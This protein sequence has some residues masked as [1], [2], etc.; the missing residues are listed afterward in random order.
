MKQRIFALIQIIIAGIIMSIIFFKLQN[1]GQ[2]Y[3]LIDAVKTAAGNWPYLL[4]TLIGLFMSAFF[5]TARWGYLL[6]AQ[7]INLKFSRQFTLYMIGQ[8]F[9]AFMLGSTGGDIVK[10]YYAAT[11]TKHLRAEVVATVIVDRIVGII[12]L[13]IL[14]TAITILR[15]NFFLSTPETK[16]AMIFNIGFMLTVTTGLLIIFKH[17]LF[18]KWRIFRKFEESTAPGRII[19]RVYNAMQLCLSKS[20][21]MPKVLFLSFLNHITL[22]TWSYY[23]ALAIGIPSGFIDILTV[24][25][26]MN[27]VASI[28]LTPNGLGTRDSTSILLF[29]AIGV[30]AATALTFSLLCYAAILT[31]SIIG[32]IFYIVYT[33]RKS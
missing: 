9:S 1:S 12:A 21:L 25:V 30:S 10:A 7:N 15:L 29:G 26:L 8:F 13:A 22:V 3:K 24:V 4:I 16:A 20:D 31:I 33:A 27:T 28:P 17:N 23:I 5:C 6:K 18:E 14:L 2:L 19:S 32:G 11:E